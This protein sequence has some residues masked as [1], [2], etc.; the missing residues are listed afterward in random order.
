[1]FRL[2]KLKKSQRGFTLVEILVVMSILAIIVIPMMNSVVKSYKLMGDAKG[3]Q[4][5]RN[6]L[7]TATTYLTKDLLYANSVDVK[8]SDEQDIIS[9]TTKSGVPNTIEFNYEK[10]MFVIDKDGKKRFI[11]KVR[12][13]A[14]N[15]EMVVK[16]A[17][18]SVTFNVYVEK[19]NAAFIST[20]TPRTVEVAK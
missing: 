11:A 6:D 18:G 3:S 14:K 7:R 2:D 12:P 17:D 1:M 19:V 16:N 13:F 10:G 9:Y 5:Q 15:E 4:V 8:N 20:I